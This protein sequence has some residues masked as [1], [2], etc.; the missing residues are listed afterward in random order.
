M[1]TLKWKDDHPIMVRIST[2]ISQA[3]E[4][5]SQEELVAIPTE[6]VYGLAGN[7]YSKKAIQAI[8]TMKR[9]P[10]Y[11]PLIVHVHD[12]KQ[13]AQLTSSFPTK[14]QE[15]AAAFWPGPLTLILP[16]SDK[17]PDLITAGKDSVGIRMPGHPLALE[18]LSQLDFPLAAPS[19]NPFT[20][21]SPTTAQHVAQY[22]THE[23]SLVLD[24]GPCTAGI[25][26]SIVGFIDEQPILYRLGSIS[27]E[28]IEQVV[29]PV[30]LITSNN[31]A[32]QAP[33]M[34]DKHYAPQTRFVLTTD[35]EKSIQ[36]NH[37]LNIGLLV[38]DNSYYIDIQHVEY[39]SKKGDLQEAATR[40]YA[41]MQRLDQLD[42]DVIIA[43]QFPDH[44]LGKSMNDR[45]RRAAK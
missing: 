21:I 24:G 28:D 36:E 32:P 33:G 40:L 10:L 11:N 8:F 3:I 9:R 37:G 6:T 39:L 20:R 19:A 22:F 44:G 18:L 42:L 27:Q 15:L 25:E 1:Q 29:G 34:I 41:A 45:L 35:V 38:H 16:K 7:I 2:D 43:Q 30:Q 31:T 12:L 26:S 14:A 23:L 13:V 17:V 5:L 4:L